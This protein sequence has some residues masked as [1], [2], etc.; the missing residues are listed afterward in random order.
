MNPTSEQAQIPG[1]VLTAAGPAL[2]RVGLH[3]ERSWASPGAGGT[4]PGYDSCSRYAGLTESQKRAYVISDNKL[5]QLSQ[6]DGNLLRS[7]LEILIRD[8]FEIETTGFST[9]VVD[10]LLDGNEQPDGTDPDDLQNEEG[11]AS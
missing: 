4:W 11:V 7:E 6:W 8:E 5:A 1:P 2:G 10:I 3:P 9:A